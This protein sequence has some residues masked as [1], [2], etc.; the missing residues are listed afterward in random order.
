[1]CLEHF[2]TDTLIISLQTV[3]MHFRYAKT[4]TCHARAYCSGSEDSSLDG[5]HSANHWSTFK[6]LTYGKSSESAV[7][8]ILAIKKLNGVSLE[9]A[10]RL[11]TLKIFPI[12]IYG[13][14][15]MREGLPEND[16]AELERV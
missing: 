7:R 6:Y 15:V 16:F 12:C 3:T 2:E 10:I 14:E 4:D 11:L 1:M 8:V 13:L 9:T 5:N